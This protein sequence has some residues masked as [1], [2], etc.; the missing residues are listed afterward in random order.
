MGWITTRGNELFSLLY[1]GKK[2]LLN[3][4]IR[5]DIDKNIYQKVTP[6]GTKRDVKKYLYTPLW[7]A[8][9]V[10]NVIFGG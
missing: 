4:D 5:Y 2:S 3:I 6:Q 8:G 1:S 10:T 9:T 7:H